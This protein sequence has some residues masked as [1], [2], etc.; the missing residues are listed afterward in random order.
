MQIEK[1]VNSIFRKDLFKKGFL[2]KEPNISSD[3]HPLHA[4]FWLTIQNQRAFL[5]SLAKKFKI[6][7]PKEWGKFAFQDALEHGAGVLLKNYG[8]SLQKALRANYPG[9]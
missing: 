7:E 2:H 4:G 5:D 9:I 6:Q 3:S 8:F 1:H